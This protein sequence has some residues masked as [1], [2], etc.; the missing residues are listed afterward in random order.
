MQD[1]S[2]ILSR[3]GIATI[4]VFRSKSE[5]V[6]KH[7]TRMDGSV[8]LGDKKRTAFG[9][10]PTFKLGDSNGACHELALFTPILCSFK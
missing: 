8:A 2:E 6:A 1:Q 10:L 4:C 7:S 9:M 5:N 3:A